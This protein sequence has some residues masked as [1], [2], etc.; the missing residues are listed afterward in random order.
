MRVAALISGGKDSALALHRALKAGHK[1]N[2]LV[3][4]IPQREDSWMFHYPNI[5][6]TYLFSEATGIPLVKAE[7]SGIKEEELE[8][9]KDLLSTLNVKG[10][11]SGAIASQYQKQRIERICQELGLSSITPLWGEEPL[12]LLKELVSLEFEAIITGVYAQ[13]FDESWLGRLIEM[14][15]IDALLQLNRK[16]HISI[17]GEGG[18]YETLV[19]DAPFFKKRIELVETEKIWQEESGWLH[20]KKATLKPK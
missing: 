6:L 12:K 1:A 2:F 4:M 8:D 17:I 19:L 20:V 16:H 7:T 15:T 13:G 9:L 18:E 14:D 10:V 5:G 11:V 3:A